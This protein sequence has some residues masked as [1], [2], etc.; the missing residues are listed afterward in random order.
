MLL[1]KIARFFYI[2]ESRPI[3]K[4]RHELCNSSNAIEERSRHEKR[5]TTFPPDGS[6]T[7]DN[8]GKLKNRLIGDEISLASLYGRIG[9]LDK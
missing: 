1:Q 2:E 3:E 4:K 8:F 7:P 6:N 5:I 9:Q